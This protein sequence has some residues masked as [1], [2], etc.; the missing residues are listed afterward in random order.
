M[1][2]FSLIKNEILDEVIAIHPIPGHSY[3]E[4]DRNFGRIEKNRLKLEKVNY[5]SEY[6][7]VSAITFQIEKTTF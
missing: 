3:L 2:Y 6:R 7:Q 1:F 4:C 5:P